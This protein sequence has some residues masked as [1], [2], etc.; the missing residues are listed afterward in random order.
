MV[1]S[2]AS[3]LEDNTLEQAKRLSRSLPVEGHVALMPDAHLGS[4]ST[5]G[6]VFQTAASIIPAAV[7][8]DIGCGMIAV[9]TD[10]QRSEIPSDAL[11]RVY[12]KIRT[13]IPAGVGGA[14]E[15]PTAQWYEFIAKENPPPRVMEDQELR[16]RASKQFGTL[17]DGNHFVELSEDDDGFVWAVLHSGSRGVGNVLATESINVAKGQCEADGYVLEDPNLSWLVEGTSEYK[18]YIGHM[19]WAQDYALAQRGAMMDVVM[20][21]LMDEFTFSIQTTINCHHNYAERNGSLWLTR[22]GAIDAS[23][24]RDGVIPGSMGEATFIVKG[25][26]NY[27]SYNSAPHGAGRLFSRG[28]ARRTLDMADFNE[29]MDGVLWQDRD[30]ETLL[31]EAPGAYKD[32]GQ[33][34][35]D[36][37]SLVVPVYRLKQFANYKGTVRRKRR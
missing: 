32:I 33:V 24:G 26:G 14:H 17:G 2:W 1:V 3:V 6:S 22:K 7:G 11:K 18:T 19:L 28:E 34:M 9:R 37:C 8:V 36:S 31:D 23:P 15:R 25:R 4:G 35:Q 13:G 12:A 21:A 20:R 29:V 5:V 10:L 27:Q 30:A 16:A